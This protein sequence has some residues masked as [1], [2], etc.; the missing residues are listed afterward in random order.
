M[1][2]RRIPENVRWRIIGMHGAGMFCRNIGV[3]LDINH[4][5]I[6]RLVRKHVET[7]HVNDRPRQGK[8]RKTTQRDDRALVRLARR[9]PM[10]TAPLLWLHLRAGVWVS[11]STIRRRLRAANLKARRPIRRLYLTYRYQ[12]ARVVWSGARRN[13]HLRTWRRIHWSDDSRLLLHKTDEPF[14]GGS[15]M[16]WGCISYDCKLDL[17]IKPMTLNAQ[18]CQQEVLGVAVI[19]QFDNHPL[20]TRPIFMDDNARPHRGRAVIAHSRNNAI[21]TL[22]WPARSPDLSIFGIFSIVKSELG[23]HRWEICQNWNRHSRGNGRESPWSASDVWLPVWGGGSHMSYVRG[24]DTPDT[25]ASVSDGLVKH[26]YSLFE[27]ILSSL[28]VWLFWPYFCECQERHFWSIQ[29]IVLI[30]CHP[31]WNCP[32]LLFQSPAHI[33]IVT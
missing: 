14:G 21:E 29:E 26:V 4:T 16:V 8:P 33:L 11:N 10:T 24:K 31:N 5:V 23:T 12:Q 2:R 17:L 19:P 28:G 20:A 18:R 3:N 7:G 1:P 32:S 25:D 9:T 15:V 6:R 22:P 27:N 13:W 30:K